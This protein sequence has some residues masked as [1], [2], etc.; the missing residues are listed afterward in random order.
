MWKTLTIIR[1]VVIIMMTF[2]S[3]GVVVHAQGTLV[4]FSKTKLTI[5]EAMVEIKA[6]TDYGVAFNSKLVDNE[7]VVNVGSQSVSL[8]DAMK[9]ILAGTG[10]RYRLKGNIIAIDKDPEPVNIV[11]EIEMPIPV[12]V[13]EFKIEEAPVVKAPPPPG[14]ELPEKLEPF[15]DLAV[16]FS[17]TPP[18]PE[19]RMC[20]LLG[21]YPYGAYQQITEPT[22]ND[23]IV[24][25]VS[26]ES[27]AHRVNIKTNLLYDA[28]AT[29]NFG[30]E[31]RTGNRTSIDVPLNINM[32]R[33]TGRNKMAW[34][35]ILVQP[36]F[37]YWMEETFS[38]HFVG[39]HGHWAKYH[40]ASLPLSDYMRNHHFDGTLAGAG[41]SWGYRWTRD[42]RLSFEVEAGI[43]YAKLN[44][45]QYN[46][47]GNCAELGRRET[48]NYF[49]PTKLAVNL[50]WSLGGRSAAQGDAK[51]VSRR[52]PL[53]LERVVAPVPVPD[54]NVASEANE[55]G[56]QTGAVSH[57]HDEN[58][59]ILI[60]ESI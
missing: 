41:V 43:G 25:P 5:R 33:S 9:E 57:E 31:F 8:D 11:Q 19:V 56:L 30:I 16:T 28:T 1:I 50:I 24:P 44:Y 36:G 21:T 35:H 4:K 37:R 15:I 18:S 55:I 27:E 12:P 51:S 23:S 3:V 13:I 39:V 47:C 54:V 34:R 17:M 22:G 7:R 48:K 6:Q 42:G 26:E 45:K 59:D 32:V 60:N 40:I 10:L 38:G 58:K 29:L 14:I 49:G 53:E 2:S 20:K 46:W 52:S